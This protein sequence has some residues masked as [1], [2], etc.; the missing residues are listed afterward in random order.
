MNTKLLT[1]FAIGLA[2]GILLA[3]EKGSDTRKKIAQ[4]SSDL[5]DKFSD[6]IDSLADKF[7]S[8]KDEA[9]DLGKKGKAKA[10]SFAS[11]AGNAWNNQS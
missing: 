3:P 8:L 6:F 1:G 2:V 11:D 4:K 9:S 7:D 10:Q 5:K